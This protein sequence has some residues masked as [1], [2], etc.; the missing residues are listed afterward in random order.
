MLFGFDA[1]PAM[2]RLQPLLINLAADI[3][4]KI[5]AAYPAAAFLA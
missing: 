1:A 4:S 3:L 2:A 5:T